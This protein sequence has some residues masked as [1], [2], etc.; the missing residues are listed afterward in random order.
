ME[1]KPC[2]FCGRYLDVNYIKFYTGDIVTLIEERAYGYIHEKSDCVLSEF[3]I[4]LNDLKAW[5]TRVGE[6]EE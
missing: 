2:P 3:S 4:G 1:L 6:V 5:N